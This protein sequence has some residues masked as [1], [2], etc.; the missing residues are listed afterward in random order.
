MKNTAFLF[1]SLLSLFP[2]KEKEQMVKRGGKK[3][4]EGKT[5]QKYIKVCGNPLRNI[6]KNLNYVNTFRCSESV[7]LN[8]RWRKEML[9]VLSAQ[10][11]Q[12]VLT[13]GTDCNSV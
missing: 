1:L 2:V 4:G 11:S 8:K 13:E 9:W 12:V 7:V 3:K 5:T 6:Q 10:C